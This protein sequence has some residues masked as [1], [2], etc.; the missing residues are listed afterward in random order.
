MDDADDDEVVSVVTPSGKIEHN[1]AVVL[2]FSVEIAPCQLPDAL[3]DK[4]YFINLAN[5]ARM[6]SLNSED[7]QLRVLKSFYTLCANMKA[8]HPEIQTIHVYMASQASLA[9]RL[10]TMI[11][12][13]V[14]P[15]MAIY[16]YNSHTGQYG[17]GVMIK[18]NHK[19]YII[20]N[21]T[22]N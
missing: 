17:W 16:Q 19:P 4:A 13:S 18:S 20:D 9:F 10:G 14:M 11:T 2:P 5:G 22:L 21:P 6:D 12:S 15:A 1:A 8:A 3:S 7:K